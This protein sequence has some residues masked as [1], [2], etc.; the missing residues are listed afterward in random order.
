M[1]GKENNDFN[2]TD[3]L[4][5]I[6]D[7]LSYPEMLIFISSAIEVETQKGLRAVALKQ[8]LEELMLSVAPKEDKSKLNQ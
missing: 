6:Q 3:F 1:V 4:E 5:L 7:T 2:R 8:G